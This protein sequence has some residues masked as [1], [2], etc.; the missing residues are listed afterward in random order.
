MSSLDERSSNELDLF[1]YDIL[2]DNDMSS[3]NRASRAIA[4]ERADTRIS[5]A[6]CR[7]SSDLK[8]FPPSLDIRPIVEVIFG[9]IVSTRYMRFMFKHVK[10]YIAIGMLLHIV[11]IGSISGN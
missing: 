6:L 4:A 1:A 7:W 11:G 8:K 9:K 5:L 3:N 2:N 10:L